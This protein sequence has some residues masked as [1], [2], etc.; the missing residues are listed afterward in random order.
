[1]AGHELPVSL[2]AAAV[3]QRECLHGARD[4]D[5]EQ[6]PFLASV[7]SAL[8]RAWGRSPSSRPATYTC[9]NS[10]PLQL[11]IVINV[12]ASP[13]LSDSSSRSV[14]SV[15]SSR[16]RCSRSPA[17]FSRKVPLS[18]VAARSFRS[19]A[20]SRPSLCLFPTAAVPPDTGLGQHALRPTGQGQ[21]R[22]CRQLVPG[23]LDEPD[24]GRQ[25]LPRPGVEDLAA[26]GFAHGA[27]H[28]VFR[29]CSGR[30]TAPSWRRSARVP[31]HSR[32][33]A[34]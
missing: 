10:R 29:S 19:A 15:R 34:G 30:A 31:G 5:V 4:R 7:P 33:A 6:P 13:A 32:C 24:E 17:G 25:A 12:T 11:C 16:N 2:P 20:G 18:R 28:E 21:I 22:G 3:A 27:E 1:M 8:D 9:G 23:R 26:G 14:S